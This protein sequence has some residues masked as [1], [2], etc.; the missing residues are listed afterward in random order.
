MTGTKTKS[1]NAKAPAKTALRYQSGFGN[2]FAS[3]A[4]EGVLPRGQNSPQQVAHGLYAEQLSGTAFTAP[5]TVNRRTWLYRIRPSVV[6]KPFEPIGAGRLRSAPFDEVPTTAEPVALDAHSDSFPTHRFYRRPDHHGGQWQHAYSRRHCDSHLRRQCFDDGPL[7]LQ[8][9]WRDADR[10]AIG[11]SAAAHRVGQFSKSRPGEI[12]VIQRGIKFPRRTAGKGSAR[13][14]LRELWRAAPSARSGTHRRERT[15][16]SARLSRRRWRR[17]EDREGDFRI[18]AKF[19]GKLW[20]AESITR[21]LNVVAWHGNYAPYK[22]DLANFQ[23]HQ[24]GE[25]RSS[26][27]IHLHGAD[28]AVGNSGNLELRFRHLSAALDGGRAYIPSAVVP[29][30]LHERVHGPDSRRLRRQGGRLSAGRR[31]PA[32]L[33]GRPRARRGYI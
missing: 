7:F 31:Q 4:V 24:Y 21:R 15:G 11:A 28:F 26:G 12:A 19:Q 9:R 2:E 18:V 22:Y 3:E 10:A 16:Q 6:H 8:R 25:F 29:S 17:Y 32:Q 30:Q 20:E 13:L 23:L 33:H 14:R 1:A 27:P 5:R